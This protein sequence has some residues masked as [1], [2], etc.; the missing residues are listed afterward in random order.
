MI[1]IIGQLPRS[2]YVA[3][4]GGVDSMAVLHFLSQSDRE[5]TVLH[6]NHGTEFGGKAYKFVENYCLENDIP[7]SF[8]MLLSETPS[9]N[10]EN[11]WREA[12]YEFFYKYDD[13]PIIMAHQL[14]DVVETYLFSAI[15][16]A[17]KL[18]PYRRDHIIR[19]F[20]TTTRDSL[21]EWCKKN[22]VPYLDDPGNVD[23][24]Y[25]RSIIRHDL[26]PVVEQINPGI[27]KVVRR[28]VLFDYR[29]LTGT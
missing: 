4:S 16:G 21:L 20:I 5:I 23:R 17:E 14:D 19:P 18:I 10:Q 27:R 24:R 2:C 1:D 15:N 22:N 12:R 8:S 26:M 28:K 9:S 7:M 25:M 3:V 29:A 11:F 6:F 13:K